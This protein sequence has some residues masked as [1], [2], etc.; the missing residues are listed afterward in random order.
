MKRILHS[1]LIGWVGISLVAC[2]QGANA[3]TLQ[4]VT[5]SL[6]PA[7]E[8]TPTSPTPVTVGLRSYTYR[9]GPFKLPAQSAPERL[10]DQPGSIAFAIEEPLWMT[11]FEPEL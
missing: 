5:A 10:A 7:I 4:P 9:V 8:T 3:P 2:S 1:S 11:A 6:P